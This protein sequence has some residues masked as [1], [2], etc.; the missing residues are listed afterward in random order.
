MATSEDRTQFAENMLAKREEQIKKIKTFKNAGYPNLEIAQR[1]GIA[2]S[3]VRDLLIPE[4]TSTS[5]YSISR[6]LLARM[7]AAH[8]SGMLNAIPERADFELADEM[9]ALLEAKLAE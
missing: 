9:I 4:H 3:T 5:P 1:M 2:E 8:T 7:V 6:D